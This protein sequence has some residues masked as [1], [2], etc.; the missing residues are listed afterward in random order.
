MLYR[1]EVNERQWINAPDVNQFFKSN[2]QGT[3]E[4]RRILASEPVTTFTCGNAHEQLTPLPDSVSKA[5]TEELILRG[6]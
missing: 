6:N 3:I 1:S 2:L 4:H 5:K